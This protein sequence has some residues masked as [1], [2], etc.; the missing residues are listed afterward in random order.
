MNLNSDS[1]I[2]EVVILYKDKL[3]DRKD[4]KKKLLIDAAVKVLSDKG[5]NDSSIIDI[6]KEAHVSVGTFY[7]YFKNKED[8]LEYIYDEISEIYFNISKFG[9]RNIKENPAIKLVKVISSIVLTYQKYQK[10]TQLLLI[11][12]S[13][14]NEKFQK[15]YFDIV[16]RTKNTIIVILK[17]MNLDSKLQD[18]DIEILAIALVK[19]VIGVLDYWIY[20]DNPKD[21]FDITYNLVLYNLNALKVEPKEIDIKKVIEELFEKYHII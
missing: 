16:D 9:S 5:Y 21:V 10:I 18:I 2:L 15:R 12:N 19:S 20:D 13:Y 3:N 4:Q 8:I 6:T 7:S 17:R 11:R 1:F 14:I